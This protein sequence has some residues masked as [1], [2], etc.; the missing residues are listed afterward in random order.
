MGNWGSIG[1]VAQTYNSENQITSGGMTYDANGNMTRD[2]AGRG[3]VYDAWNRMVKQLNTDGSTQTTYKVDALGRRIQ[4]GNQKFTY[5]KDWQVIQDESSITLRQYVWS[6]A[7]V[8]AM[9]LRDFNSDGNMGTGNQ[10]KAG[11]G[12]D[13]RIYPMQDA[14]WN[15]TGLVGDVPGSGIIVRERYVYDPYGQVTVLKADWSAATNP[16]TPSWA[17][18]YLHQGGGGMRRPGCTTSGTAI[19]HRRWGDG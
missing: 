19:T 11:S 2:E 18:Y 15:V 13:Q 16:T 6:L 1:G 9:V 8:D 10:G 3:F 17:W 7:Y 12:L 5:S 14:N 4:A